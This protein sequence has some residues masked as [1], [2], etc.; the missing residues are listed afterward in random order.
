MPE[1]IPAEPGPPLWTCDDCGWTCDSI[2][3][4]LPGLP[5]CDNCGGELWLS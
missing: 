3:P 2:P 1:L 5:E 4:D